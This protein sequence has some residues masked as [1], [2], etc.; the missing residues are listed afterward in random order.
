MTTSPARHVHAS[1]YYVVAHRLTDKRT[2][3]Y[4]HCDGSTRSAVL[5]HAMT[6]LDMPIFLG[7][8]SC[9]T[10][11]TSQ[12]QQRAAMHAPREILDSGMHRIPHAGTVDNQPS[13]LRTIT[14]WQA[15]LTVVLSHQLRR[16]LGGVGTS[17]R[18]TGRSGGAAPRK[19]RRSRFYHRAHTPCVSVTCA[20]P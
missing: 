15:S 9:D 2:P 10:G 20:L 5:A 19:R 4:T 11:R 12:L 16:P 17:L 1:G 13:Y 7:F 18:P 8:E 3:C 14:R 6:K